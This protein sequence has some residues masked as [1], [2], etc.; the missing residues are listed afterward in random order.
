MRGVGRVPAGPPEG[1]GRPGVRR[2]AGAVRLSGARALSVLL[3]AVVLTGCSAGGTGTRDEGP[4]HTG[5]VG[6]AVASP[7]PTPEASAAP[8]RIDAVRL[9]RTDPDVAPE[10]KR[11]LKRCAGNTYPVDVS[12]GRLTGGT[13]DDVVVNVMTCDAVGVGSYVYR[14]SAR[15]SPAASPA[16]PGTYPDGYENVFRDEEPPVYA[17]IDR[18]D[19]V[20][21]QKVYEKGDQVAYPSSED[22]IVYRWSASGHRFTEQERTHNDYSNAVGGEKSSTSGN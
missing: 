5:P 7:T 19:L 6:R 21:T 16:P 13:A 15:V 8:S 20:V 2:H 14:R 12:Y 10:V 18:G 9:V 11:G 3:A 1:S 17:A 22:V 4:A